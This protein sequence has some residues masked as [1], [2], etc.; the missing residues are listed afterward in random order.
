MST[1]PAHEHYLNSHLGSAYG[2]DNVTKR[3][4]P[5]QAALLRSDTGI[6]GISILGFSLICEFNLYFSNRTLH[7]GTGHFNRRTGALRNQWSHVRWFRS[8]AVD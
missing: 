3:F 4:S 6:D 1:P 7:G 5:S 8:R 2:L